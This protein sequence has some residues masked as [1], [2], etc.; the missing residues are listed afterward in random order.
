MFL[1]ENNGWPSAKR[2]C[3]IRTKFFRI[4]NK[5]KTFSIL[6]ILL[7]V[8]QIFRI[9]DKRFFFYFLSCF[10]VGHG[11]QDDGDYGDEINQTKDG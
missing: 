11:E 8:Q 10:L 4:L 2:E 6:Y 7:I 1:I 5:N 9:L 3:E